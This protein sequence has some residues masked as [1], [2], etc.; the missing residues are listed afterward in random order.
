MKKL[1]VSIVILLCVMSVPVP[2]QA[3]TTIR[4]TTKTVAL[5]DK[6]NGKTIRK[7]KANTKMRINK[8]GK[9]WARV[10]YKSKEYAVKKKYLNKQNSP[11]RYTAAYFRKAGR[12]NWRGCSFTYY[13][14]RVLPGGGLRIPGR[15]VDKRGFVC[16][17]DGYIVIASTVNMKKKHAVVA[18]PFGK[19]GKVY[20]CGAGS[21]KWRD[22]YVAW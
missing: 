7:V 15:H 13:S 17:K 6:A 19:F 14:Q 9:V 1:L 10:K 20:D 16:D 11:K 4:Y 22:V 2:A 21:S 8:T 5:K 18:T 3:S 12:I